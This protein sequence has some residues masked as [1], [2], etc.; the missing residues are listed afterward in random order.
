M[1]HSSDIEVAARQF[2][3]W[4][5]WAIRE[6]FVAGATYEREACA[7]MIENHWDE[8]TDEELMDDGGYRFDESASRE[9]IAIAIRQRGTP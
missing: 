9:S 1:N 5:A 6:A 8:I 3:Y 7:S 4:V 2:P